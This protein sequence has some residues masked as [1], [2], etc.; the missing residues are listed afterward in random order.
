MLAG[1][2]GGEH[3]GAELVQGAGGAV[4]FQG[5][6]DGGD[7]PVRRGGVGRVEFAAGQGQVPGGFLP[8]FNPGVAAGPGHPAAGRGRVDR[9]HQGPQRVPQLP[10]RHRGGAGQ[11]RGSGRVRGPVTER[12]EL[13]GEHRRPGPV[14]LPGE[15][16]A[17]DGGKAGEVAGQAEQ[18]VG[19]PAGQHQRGGELGGDV[20]AD[21]R[22]ARPGG[23]GGD[24]GGRARRPRRARSRTA[25]PTTA[26][27]RAA[28]PPARHRTARPGRPG[29]DA[30]GQPGQ[31]PVR[32]ELAEGAAVRRTPRPARL[33][34]PP[35]PSHPGLRRRGGCRDRTARRRWA[36]P[37]PPPR[38]GPARRC[39]GRIRPAGRG[40]L[41]GGSWRLRE[42]DTAN[43]FV[44]DN[45]TGT[46]RQL[47]CVFA[48]VVGCGAAGHRDYLS[49]LASAT[50][51]SAIARRL[52]LY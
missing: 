16:G 18:Q 29:P 22:P 8:G 51:T 35:S 23:F 41:A 11:H 39:R 43:E 17:Q 33:G 21:L 42:R 7:P 36:R 34:P 20:L 31:R 12:G 50:V 24:G 26:G 40:C 46:L 25:T 5:L 38:P 19:G 27:T 13:G 30:A 45:A 32:R 3:R 15:Q 44:I 37:G 9:Q 48:T 47:E 2:Q 49:D 52:L 1:E 28:A 14:D 10:G 4:V 6:G